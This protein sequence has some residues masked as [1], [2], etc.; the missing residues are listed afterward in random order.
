MDSFNHKL[1]IFNDLCGKADIPRDIYAKTFSIIQRNEIPTP[2]SLMAD[3]SPLEVSNFRRIANDLTKFHRPAA[4]DECEGYC[5]GNPCDITALSWW[6][7]DS[8]R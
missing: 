8:K 5:S 6:L 4:N 1:T 3:E 7:Q 2:I